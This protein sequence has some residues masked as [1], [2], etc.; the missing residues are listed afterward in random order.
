MKVF[1]NAVLVYTIVY[2]GAKH[3]V[4]SPLPIA[5]GANILACHTKHMCNVAPD[6]RQATD[7]LLWCCNSSIHN[8]TCSYSICLT[9]MISYKSLLVI[10]WSTV[11]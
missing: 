4:F 10:T 6:I 2:E 5:M 8:N 7:S 11:H 9:P 3:L 1:C